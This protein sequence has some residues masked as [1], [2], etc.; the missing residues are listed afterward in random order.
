MSRSLRTLVSSL[1]PTQCS[2]FENLR[3][4]HIPSIIYFLLSGSKRSVIICNDSSI[5]K[6]PLNITVNARDVKMKS[7]SILSIGYRVVVLVVPNLKP[8]GV[9]VV[10]LVA[11]LVVL[12]PPLNPIGV[13]VVN[14]VAILVVFFDFSHISVQLSMFLYDMNNFPPKNT[15]K[16]SNSTPRKYNIPL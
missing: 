2:Y 14:Q 15:D 3:L 13:S 10:N 7:I 4:I 12:M 1:H 6:L 9:S 11:V 5:D 16:Y 8:I